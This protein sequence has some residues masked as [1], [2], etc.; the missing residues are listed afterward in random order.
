VH[1]QFFLSRL[2]A[3]D[4]RVRK[5][6]LHVRVVAVGVPG[7]I[8]FLHALGELRRFLFELQRGFE[9]VAA[10]REKGVMERERCQTFNYLV[11]LCLHN[12]FTKRGSIEHHKHLT[13]AV[14]SLVSIYTV[15]V[16]IASLRRKNTATTVKTIPRG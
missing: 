2:H 8:I 15:P 5:T 11:L 3:R 14:P 13:A 9:P 16:A 12:I 7:E 4:Q 1:L 10:V 6:A